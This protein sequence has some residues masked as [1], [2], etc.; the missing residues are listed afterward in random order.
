M[1]LLNAP[2]YDK[3]KE[4]RN[5]II[6]ISAIV[7][8]FAIAIIGVTGY[9]V[10]HGWFFSDLPAE[11]RVSSFFTALEKG[12]YSRAFAIKMNDPD[13]AQHPDRYKNY[14][15]DEFKQ[16]WTTGSQYGPI[17]SHHVDISKR[18]GTGSGASIVVKVRIN[19]MTKKEAN[20]LSVCY[21]L[22]DKTLIDCP[23][24]LSY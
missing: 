23:I 20:P 13:W 8:V 1:T 5:N 10:G 16:D 6:L 9:F 2:A 21:L 11:W 22:Q 7:L 17:H 15:F 18:V 12:D 3:S 19:G 24:D 4:R 14:T